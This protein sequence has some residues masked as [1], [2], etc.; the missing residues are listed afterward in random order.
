[1]LTMKHMKC[2]M[3]IAN[4]IENVSWH[5]QCYWFYIY[6]S[7]SYFIVGE[8]KI[9]PLWFSWKCTAMETETGR[10]LET[11]AWTSYIYSVC[12]LAAITETPLRVAVRHRLI[13][14]RGGKSLIKTMY[15]LGGAPNISTSICQNEQRC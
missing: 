10:F 4:N 5:S 2:F 11:V 14:R 1:M 9:R 8:Y 13:P 3:H 12:V 6:H 15:S 7:F